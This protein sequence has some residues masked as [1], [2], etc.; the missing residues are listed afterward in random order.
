MYSET[1]R[2]KYA[3]IMT[4][5]HVY[6]TMLETWENIYDDFQA[7]VRDRVICRHDL[8][9]HLNRFF[10]E[11]FISKNRQALLIL[12]QGSIR[13][14]ETLSSFITTMLK[15]DKKFREGINVLW[16]D[17]PYDMS[18]GEYISIGLANE[19]LSYVKKTRER[20]TG[21]KEFVICESDGY[22]YFSVPDDSSYEMRTFDRNDYEVIHYGKNWNPSN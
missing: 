8:I 10:S 12:A 19:L 5:V 21:H 17:C 20:W 14:P 6:D 3:N 2:L 16:G 22:M 7:D 13:D 9:P 1:R 15:E 18:F 11:E 4:T